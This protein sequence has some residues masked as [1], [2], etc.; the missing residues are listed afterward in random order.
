MI[1]VVNR[2]D[3]CRQRVIGLVL[4]LLDEKQK[5]VYVSEPMKDKSGKTTYVELDNVNLTDFPVTMTYYPPNPKPIWDE[6]DDSDIPPNMKCRTLSTPFNEEGGGN[7]V[8]LD[9]HNVACGP[10]ETLGRFHLVRESGPKGPTGK[11]RYD[12]T[13]CQS[14]MP[15]ASSAKLDELS[16]NVQRIQSQLTQMTQP[17][18]SAS[19]TLS[20]SSAPPPSRHDIVPENNLSP[21]GT[22]ASTLG[23]QSG[24][25]RDIHNIIRNELYAKRSTTP[26]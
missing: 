18:P 5:P 25:I 23:Q 15:Q 11:Y 16:S 6:K 4:S 12:Y 22:A 1:H 20:A 13:C 9:R 24:L 26:L 19:S 2:R 3:C 8:Y 17:T 21:I 7:A 14:N 10:N